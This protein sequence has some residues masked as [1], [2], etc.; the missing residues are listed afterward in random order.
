MEAALLKRSSGDV[1]L[2]GDD[3]DYL[4][5]TGLR[6]WWRIFC[7]ESSKL[8]TIGGPIAFQIICQFASSSVATIFVGHLGDVELSAFSMALSVIQTFAFGFMVSYFFLELF[9]S[10]NRVVLA[11]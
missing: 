4:P 7:I 8:W 10:S 9:V 1:E 2:I 3:G 11:S 5:A 6:A